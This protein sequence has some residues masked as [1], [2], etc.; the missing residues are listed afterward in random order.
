MCPLITQIMDACNLCAARACGREGWIAQ[1]KKQ[2]KNENL[3][4]FQNSFAFVCSGLGVADGANVVD[5]TFWRGGSDLGQTPLSDRGLILENRRGFRPA[6]RK[7]MPSPQKIS[8]IA[9]RIC[10]RIPRLRPKIAGIMAAAQSFRHNSP[11]GQFWPE[12]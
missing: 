2:G 12:F 9:A 11:A 1:S 7:Y 4:L 3:R 6:S 8:G 5:W 10:R